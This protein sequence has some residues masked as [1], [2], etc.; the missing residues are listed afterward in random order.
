[1]CYKAIFGSIMIVGRI[2]LVG[3]FLYSRDWKLVVLGTLYSITD[4]LIFLVKW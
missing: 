4:T 2:G 1:M 3:G